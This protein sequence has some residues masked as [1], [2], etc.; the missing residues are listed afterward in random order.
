M[1]RRKKWFLSRL[2][3]VKD[4]SL[5]LSMFKDMGLSNDQA[6]ALIKRFWD[7]IPVKSIGEVTEGELRR[8]L[9]AW[10]RWA[11]KWC[12][13]HREKFSGEE[14]ETLGLGKPLEKGRLS[15]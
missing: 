4:R 5:A 12:R 13:E 9:P 2:W 8:Y 11:Q 10:D 3:L 7:G 6:R 14:L 15:G 1:A